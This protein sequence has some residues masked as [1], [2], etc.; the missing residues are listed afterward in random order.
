MP[1]QRPS[2]DLFLAR[3][4]Y[5]VRTR[6]VSGTAR[7]FGVNRSTIF[8]WRTGRTRPSARAS[9]NVTQTVLRQQQRE[10]ESGEAEAVGR[11]RRVGNRTI[12][13][14]SV[15]R[16][17]DVIERQRVIT[18]TRAIETARTDRDRVMAESLPESVSDEEI[19][20]LD[21]LI[22]RMLDA[23]DEEWIT[24]GDEM[25]MMYAQLTG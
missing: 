7:R 20:E 8:R 16:R 18:R 2:D 11:A 4:E 3:L 23:S 24:D 9:R 13:D 25:R 22:Q 17:I 10:F 6:G 12:A 5:S 21:A 14:P 19:S 1:Q 15:T